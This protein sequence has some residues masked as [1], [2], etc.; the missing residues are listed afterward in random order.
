MNTAS[1]I[2][3]ELAS[4]SL[5]II[6]IGGS[7]GGI[8]I[9]R[10]I[11]RALPAAFPVPLVAVLHIGAGT[12]AAWSHVFADSVLPVHEVEDKLVAAPAAVYV[13]PPDYHL[14]VDGN[15]EL[16]LSVDPA[17][18]LS[19]PSI[20]VLFESV[21]FSFGARALGIVLSGA[22]S[23][24]AAGLLALRRAGGLAWVQ[25]PE[26]APVQAMPRAALSAVP[27]AH[28]MTPELMVEVLHAYASH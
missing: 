19:R 7:A 1:T 6:A 20:D 10:L 11:L 16:V 2:Q 21:A 3:T 8:E 22:N 13:A 17:V 9:L 4:R 5:A 26:S 15:G 12:K 27:D 24:G 18:Q 23:D 14:L 25:A 28:V